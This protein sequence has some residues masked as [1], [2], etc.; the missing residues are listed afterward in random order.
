MKLARSG[1]RPGADSM[2]TTLH[3]NLDAELDGGVR[4][5]KIGDWEAVTTDLV[6]QVHTGRLRGQ[7]FGAA[8]DGRRE[9]RVRAVW[10]AEASGPGAHGVDLVCVVSRDDQA[11]VDVQASRNSPGSPREVLRP[12][13][14]DEI[15]GRGGTLEGLVPVADQRPKLPHPIDADEPHLYVRR[16]LPDGSRLRRLAHGHLLDAHAPRCERRQP[17]VTPCPD[18]EGVTPSSDHPFRTPREPDH[19][20]PQTRSSPTGTRARPS[21]DTE[22]VA[23]NVQH[24]DARQARPY[25]YAGSCEGRPPVRRIP[26]RV[27][28]CEPLFEVRG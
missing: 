27:T 26:R 9:V 15:P 23:L 14:R 13:E 28:V 20:K 1:S 16:V 19:L 7:G 21:V 24:R 6:Q 22:L 4:W 8:V 12:L 2:S 25:R 5:P 11:Q 10:H 3:G 18:A 17:G